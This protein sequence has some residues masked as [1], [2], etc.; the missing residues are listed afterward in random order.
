MYEGKGASIPEHDFECSRLA[1]TG[2]SVEMRGG[3]YSA[4]TLL[5]SYFPKERLCFGEG[6]FLAFHAAWNDLKK[7]KLRRVC[8]HAD[9]SILPD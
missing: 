8:D 6:A 5:T 2:A 1:E 4:C 7:H 9:V 3:C